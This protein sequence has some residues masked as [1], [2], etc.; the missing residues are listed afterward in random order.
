VV[1]TMHDDGVGVGVGVDVVELE[2]RPEWRN[3]STWLRRLKVSSAIQVQGPA[4]STSLGRI[5]GA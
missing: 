4:A 5:S 1:V 2:E 3:V